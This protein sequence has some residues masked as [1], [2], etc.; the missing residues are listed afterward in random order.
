MDAKRCTAGENCLHPDGPLL[1]ISEFGKDKSGKNG[2]HARCKI[3]RYAKIKAWN[4]AHRERTREY[5]RRSRAQPGYR[6]RQNEAHRR[7]R[8]N[9]PDRE[10]EQQRRQ[11]ENHPEKRAAATK[12]WQQTHPDR[13]RTRERRRRSRQRLLPATFT[14]DNW[15]RAL[16]Y[17]GGRC[18]YC[19]NPPKLWDNPRVLAQDHF[20]PI[21]SKGGYTPE[22]VL[23]SCQFCNSSKNN[24]DP[25]E[26]LTR[27][28]GKRKANQ[29]L[30][31]IRE[32]FDW[33]KSHS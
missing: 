2:L 14:T 16:N 20:I 15:E 33:I 30:K 27:R 21:S 18:A 6:E 17:W 13:V 28:F 25:V 29:I 22:N 12:K 31:A 7:W 32:Y 26:W 3:C 9:N 10:R 19:G 24:S 11:R 8:N 4:Q 23:P 1:P 5:S